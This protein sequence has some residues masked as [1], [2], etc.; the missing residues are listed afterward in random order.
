MRVFHGEKL[1]VFLPIGPLFLQR[2]L[3]KTRFDPGRN[4]GE[5]DPRL[6]HVVLVFV[7]RDGASTERLLVD[8]AEKWIL[9]ASLHAGF[10]EVA[11]KQT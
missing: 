5:V 3:A 10:N 8:G 9:L 2:R 7:T 6:L 1:E 11:H 4:P